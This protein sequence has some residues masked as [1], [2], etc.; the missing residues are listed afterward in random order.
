MLRAG[1]MHYA[2]GISEIVNTEQGTQFTAGLWIHRHKEHNIK[3]SL[4]YKCSMIAW[5][6]GVDMGYG[7]LKLWLVIAISL[8]LWLIRKQSVN[9]DESCSLQSGMTNTSPWGSSHA[10]IWPPVRALCVQE[11]TEHS[12]N[13][14]FFAARIQWLSQ[15]GQL[16]SFLSMCQTTLN[17]FFITGKIYQQG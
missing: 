14:L 17:S 4:F 16:H 9:S 7:L 10:T 13:A 6:T 2:K 1:K 12:G 11:A 3:I 5:E 15:L 8:T